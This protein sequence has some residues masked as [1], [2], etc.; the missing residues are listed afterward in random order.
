MFCYEHA[1]FC[2]RLYSPEFGPKAL[3]GADYVGIAA[4]SGTKLTYASNINQNHKH[5][6]RT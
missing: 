5:H 4:I 3:K 2:K 6:N 1:L